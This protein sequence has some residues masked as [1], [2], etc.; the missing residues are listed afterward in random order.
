[1]HLIHRRPCV[2]A[3]VASV[4]MAVMTGCAG[5][6]THEASTAELAAIGAFNTQYLKA[7]ND[8]DIAALSRL[9]TDDHIMMMPN[10]PPVE[11]KGANDAINGRAF[12]QFRFAETW[13][14]IET[15]VSGDLAYQR[16]TFTTTAT[17]KAG[18][19]ARTIAGKFLRI[20]RREADGSW[21]MV[22]DMFN[23][24]S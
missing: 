22:I 17:P 7:I 4:L 15:R 20:Y 24:G 19:A 21:R 14:P 16:G 6:R 1:M 18:G 3:A 5:T 10:R 23:E 2:L 9:T 12:E 8:G 13:T 11:G